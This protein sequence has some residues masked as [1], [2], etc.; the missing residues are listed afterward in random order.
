MLNTPRYIRCLCYE[1]GSSFRALR[2]LSEAEV[3]I[4]GRDIQSRISVFCTSCVDL[5]KKR[6]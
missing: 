3:G 2:R 1:V 5:G 4:P 6:G